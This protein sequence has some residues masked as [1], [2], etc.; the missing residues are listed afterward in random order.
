MPD[1]Q[2]PEYAYKNDTLPADLE[3][4][5]LDDTTS[6]VIFIVKSTDNQQEHIPAHKNLLAT[7]S[8]VFH[9]MFYGELKEKL[10]V[11]IGHTTAA[12]FREFLQFF[13]LSKAK[14]TMKNVSKVMDLGKMYNVSSSFDACVKL[15]KTN[16]TENNVCLAYRLAILYD[17]EDLMQLCVEKIIE[18]TESVFASTSFLD[19]PKSVLGHILNLDILSCP[20]VDVFKACIDWVQWASGKPTVTIEDVHQYL[21]DLF[22]AIRFRSMTIQEFADLILTF[23]HLFSADDENECVQMT[24]SKEYVPENFTAKIRQLKYI[25]TQCNRI[26]DYSDKM[27]YFRDAVTTFSTNENVLLVELVLSSLMFF[28]DKEWRNVTMD[29]LPVEMSII[30]I[31]DGIGRRKVLW[32]GT[33]GLRCKGRTVLTLSKPIFSRPGY[34]YKI[35]LKNS[36]DGLFYKVPMLKTEVQIE[37]NI[38]IQFHND[39]KIRRTS[40]SISPIIALRFDRNSS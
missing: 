3:R 40:L 11:K 24:I 22:Y 10:D 1:T 33:A 35:M 39:Q 20:E 28:R 7:R 13:Y 31:P 32:K 16:L 17:E 18:N 26:V 4:L 25:F 8:D 5:Y 37:P 15:L 6:D 14:L 9:A 27:Y 34:K 2:T 21:A 36:A 19:S 12:A 30:E 29:F 38:I 23:G